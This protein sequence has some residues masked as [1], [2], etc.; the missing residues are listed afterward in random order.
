[1]AQ[2]ITIAVDDDLDG[3]R[4]DE[5]VRF[6]IGTDYEIDL[7]ATHAA[8]FRQ[9]RWPVHRARPQDRAWP[10]RSRWAA[11]T[12]AMSGPG[13]RTRASPSVTGRI[14]AS[15]IA[16][17]QAAGRPQPIRSASQRPPADRSCPSP[18]I[19]ELR[20][21]ARTYAARPERDAESR[22]KSRRSARPTARGHDHE[23][24]A[25]GSICTRGSLSL[26]RVGRAREVL[27]L[28]RCAVLY[29]FRQ[30]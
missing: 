6:G 21:G 1:M 28:V 29:L 24:H 10:A 2:K 5:A 30:G 27:R 9:A 14:P 3:G 20:L 15:V 25:Y 12:T 11:S 7:N 23:R 19:K 8:A 22:A 17:Y 4:A 18:S 16:Q 26:T 13:P